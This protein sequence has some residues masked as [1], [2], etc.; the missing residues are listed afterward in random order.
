M[1]IMDN[2][3]KQFGAFE[4]FGVDVSVDY[5]PTPKDRLNFQISYMDTEWTD[6][7]VDFYWSW[8]WPDQGR[9]FNGN[10]ATMSPE[11]TLHAS[12]EHR[13]DLGSVGTLIPQVDVQY[14]TSFGII[15][16]TTATVTGE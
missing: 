10:V 12:Y 7:V 1:N 6:A 5:V 4:T 14:K 3:D 8:V 11:W 15:N 9:N 13:F 2:Y 16:T